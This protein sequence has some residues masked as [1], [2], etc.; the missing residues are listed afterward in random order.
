M[1]VERRR[2]LIEVAFPLEEVSDE[3]RID[4]YRGP[5]HPQTLH[6]WWARR[7]L[8]VCRAF[9]YASLIDDPGN[10]KERDELL[11]EVAD[12]AR[13]DA[14]RKPDQVVRPRDKGGSGLTGV[15]LLERARQRILECNGGKPPRLLD[16]F[17]GGGAIPLEALRLGCEV[18]ASDLNPVAVLILKGTVEY[19]QKYGRPLAEQA[20]RKRR[21]ERDSIAGVNGEVPDY[22]RGAA[23]GSQASFTDAD[24][25]EAY[26]KNP[27]ATDVRYWGDEV[28][29]D[30]RE[31]LSRYYPADPNG[32]T[33]VAYLWC[34][35]VTCPNCRLRTPLLHDTKLG[36]DDDEGVVWLEPIGD[37]GQLAFRLARGDAAQARRGTSARAD[38]KCVSCNQ[39][40]KARDIRAIARSTGMGMVLTAVVM[41]EKKRGRKWFR[42]ATSSD[43]A[44]YHEA[45]TLVTTNAE[46]LDE[47]TGL[48]TLPDEP[49]VAGTLG[50]RV[51][52]Y[53]ITRWSQLFNDRQLLLML[54]LTLSVRRVIG[55]MPECGLSAEYADGI[56]AYLGLLLG[57]V[58]RE[59]N[60]FA[61]WNPSGQKP[62]GV[63]SQPK[64]SMVWDYA[65]A[66]PFGG[67]VGDI[68]SA[69]E[70]ICEAIS[71]S[72]DGSPAEVQLADA[73]SSSFYSHSACVTDPPY[74]SALDYAGLSDFFYV[75]LKRALHGTYPELLHLP[76]TPKTN[77]AIMRSERNDPDE[78]ARYVDLMSK[79]FG[80]IR[81]SSLAAS[82]MGVVFA[83]ADPD[84]WST[85]IESLLDADFLPHS[86]WPIDTESPTKIANL[87][88]ARLK[89]SVWMACRPR[90][91]DAGEAFIGDVLQEMRP[92]IKER[93][94]YF[95]SKGVRGAD[96]FISA[97]GPALSVFGQHSKVLRPDGTEVSVR[98]FLDLVRRESTQ[99]ALEQVLMGADLGIVDPVTRQYVTWV[100]SYSRAPL[101]A[102]ETIALCLATGA[103]YHE[104]VRPGAIAAEVKEKS[105][106]LVKL[107]TIKERGQQDED[108]GEDS[109]ARPAPLVDQLQRAAYIWGLN[110]Q[111]ELARFRASLGETRWAALR[112]LGQ[113]VAECLPDG[114][115]DRR[116]INGLLGSS[117]MASAAPRVASGHPPATAGGPLPGFEEAMETDA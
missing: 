55:K 18:E 114:D 89:T 108:L 87:G 82:T 56:S 63:F 105:K 21:G 12:L 67:S 102:G 2:R 60:S 90:E 95:W 100:W 73:T 6:P 101:D 33:P 34:R 104:A 76:L 94:L 27:L 4:K 81:K 38:A 37:Q 59:N 14:V 31:E 77:Q 11:R 86:S 41:S 25:V 16:P 92:V 15:Q 91:A 75:W 65:E 78:R 58:A 54:S 30:V 74:Y 49:I 85:L 116:L 79:S 19:P 43:V 46:S 10:D 97:I 110:R 103:D 5:P 88:K 35:T 96:F 64:L 70:I 51:P 111:E 115:E 57:R 83:H 48:T 61:T 71:Q 13:W 24:L 68:Q 53:G 20:E 39:V 52:A 50:V 22:I 26:R 7:P 28:I 17:A 99:V 117:V 29:R 45:A 107:R 109:P 62:Q 80:R 112:T 36:R 1:T 32:S 47:E 44:T 42:E 69:L 23:A 113:A 98:D 66:N 3:S 8:P 93:L 9:I 84:A 106:K 72:A 40:I